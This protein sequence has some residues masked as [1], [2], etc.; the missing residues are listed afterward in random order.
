MP[1]QKFNE[2]FSP[3]KA[4]AKKVWMDG[5]IVD[6]KDAKVHILT[7]SLHYG[8]AVF[9][10]TRAYKTDKGLAIFRLQ[11][12]TKRLLESA[13]ITLLK[14]PY[15][16]DELEKAQIEIIK[17]NEFKGNVYLRPLVYLGDG[18][19]G[20][21]HLKAPVRV[22][23]AAWEMG[24]YLGE[25]GLQ[26]GIRVKISSFMRNSAKS[27]MNKAKASANYLNSQLAKF[28]AIDAGYE[29]GLL[30]D[31]EGFI[32]EGTGECF[33]IV[34]NGAL[35]TPPNDFTLRSI[36]QDTVLQIA[37]SRNLSVLRQRISRDEV[38]TAD[39]AFFT[40]TAAEITPIS[41]I[42]GR[43]IGNGARGEL[44]KLLQDAFFDIVY[45]RDKNFSSMLT[46]V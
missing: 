27:S 5:Q 22:A 34:K 39:E 44:T 42:D 37:K 10:G 43:V 6:F 13:K 32:S 30:L 29:E 31:E 16:Q 26:K 41:N 33:F 15:S 20:V 28:E 25:E 40:G 14:V 7:H 17:A 12:H 3:M 24:A 1:F 18:E 23:I 35:I 19:M 36:T 38:Y 45:G 46:Y 11:E 2:R 4:E 9:E 21:Y 8:N